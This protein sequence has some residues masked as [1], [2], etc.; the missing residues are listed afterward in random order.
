MLKLEKCN[1]E[2]LCVDCDDKECQ[3]VGSIEADCPQ[4]KCENMGSG[5]D[6]CYFIKKYQEDYRKGILKK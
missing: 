4:W 5:C 2:K 6:N 3:F 1:V